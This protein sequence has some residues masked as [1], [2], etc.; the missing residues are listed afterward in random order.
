MPINS[1]KKK[2]IDPI[3]WIIKYL[4]P[5]HASPLLDMHSI[6]TNLKRFTSKNTHAKKKE[7]EETPRVILATQMIAKDAGRMVKKICEI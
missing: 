6:A 7:F 5:D 2:I 4:K 3:L 1:D